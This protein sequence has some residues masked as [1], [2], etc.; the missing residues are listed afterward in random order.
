MRGHFKENR[1]GS[2]R[3]NG[4]NWANQ[5]RM[6]RELC[7]L[8]GCPQKALKSE[9]NTWLYAP[10]KKQAAFYNQWKFILTGTVHNTSP[11]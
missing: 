6:K 10:R 3:G 8:T 2:P 7:Y 4:E 1:G 9:G 5:I 11:Y